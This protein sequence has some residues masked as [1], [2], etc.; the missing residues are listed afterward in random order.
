MKREL[1]RVLGVV[2]RVPD[3]AWFQ[4]VEQKIDDLKVLDG[5]ALRI[6]ELEERVEDHETRIRGIEARR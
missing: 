2:D 5:H 4:R 6:G 3:K 1:G